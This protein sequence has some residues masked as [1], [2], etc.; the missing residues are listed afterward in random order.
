MSTQMNVCDNEMPAR[1][2][3]RAMALQLNK[4][5]EQKFAGAGA[6]KGL[7][8]VVLTVNGHEVDVIKALAQLWEQIDGDVERRALERAKEMITAAGL[9]K[10]QAALQDAEWRIT[11][12]LERVARN[13]EGSRT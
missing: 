13:S 7:C 3:L 5:F 8:E 12:A 10:I 4:G 2:V 1:I 6:D 9:D 11:E